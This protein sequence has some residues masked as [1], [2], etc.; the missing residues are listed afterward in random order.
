MKKLEKTIQVTIEISL[1]GLA[2][3]LL[4]KEINRSSFLDHE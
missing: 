1:V 4:S 3:V 2:S